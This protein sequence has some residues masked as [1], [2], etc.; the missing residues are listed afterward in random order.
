MQKIGDIFSEIQEGANVSNKLIYNLID[1]FTNSATNLI[2]GLEQCYLKIIKMGSRSN[3]KPIERFEKITEK[4][5]S[6]IYQ[7]AQNSKS[8][9][10]I[11]INNVYGK[12]LIYSTCLKC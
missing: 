1:E 12:F 3:K 11:D 7:E 4:F 2:N 10:K 6:L 8:R 5:F 9:K